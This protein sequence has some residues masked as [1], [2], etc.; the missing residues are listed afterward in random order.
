MSLIRAAATVSG[1]TL[2]SRITGLIRDTLIASIF[3]VSALTD[4]FFVAWR[5]PNLLRRLFAEGAFAQAFV[6]ILVQAKTATGNDPQRIKP[7]LNNVSTALFWALFV[8]AGIGVIAAPALVW[9][10]AS[11]LPDDAWQPAVTMTRWMFPYIFFISLVALAASILNTWK[12]FAI[13]AFAP[14]LLNLCF[15]AASLTLTKTFSQPIYALAAGVVF[16]GIAQLGLQVWAL[17][18]RDLLPAIFLD[19]RPAFADPTTRQVISQM[20]PALLGVSVAQISLIVNTHIASRLQSGSVSWI[21]Y[22]DRLME[23]P[24]ALLG[25]ALGTVLLP[26]L[27]K[28]NAD[29]DLIKFSS[30]IDWGLRLSLLL[31]IPATV[32]L[33]LM[34]EPLTA[35]LFHYGR[36]SA[37]DVAMT[38]FAVLGYAVGLVGLISIKIL[39]P[40]FYAA[41][42]IKTPVKVAIG[43]LILTQLLNLILVPLLSKFGAEGA[44][45]G[46]VGLTLAISLGAL[47]N[48]AVLAYLLIK[49]NRYTPSKGWGLFSLQILGAGLAMAAHLSFFSPRFDWVSMQSEPF[50]R[51]MIAGFVIVSAASVYGAVL[52]ILGV[53]PK[54]YFKRTT[55]Q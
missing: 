7:L 2:I 46:H 11:G 5:L 48:A 1:L 54:A 19:P 47:V 40:G 27:A 24:T 35:F 55:S 25:V 29:G 37:K 45:L 51:I 28:A 43:V 26:S 4:A 9:L 8:V 20:A 34:A 31:A 30:L 53:N 39:A 17:K 22:A 12:H 13:P 6:P 50:R 52:L 38:Q 15:I 21:T 42:D 44:S 14:V 41:K 3:G 10:M 32:G 23:F 16:G 36:F 33:A 49:T 18:K